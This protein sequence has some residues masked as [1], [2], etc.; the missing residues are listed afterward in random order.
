MKFTQEER[1]ALNHI[2]LDESTK[3]IQY[4]EKAKERQR[5]LNLL[6]IILTTIGTVCSAIA[7]ITSIIALIQ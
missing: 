1:D 7:A 5:K 6:T 3:I 4:L 2:C